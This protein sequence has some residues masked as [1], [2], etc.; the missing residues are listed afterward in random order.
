MSAPAVRFTRKPCSPR[1]AAYVSAKQC[2]AVARRFGGIGNDVA[3]RVLPGS[4]VL[5]NTASSDGG[6]AGGTVAC[7]NAAQADRQPWLARWTAAGPQLPL[8]C[9][10]GDVGAS[11]PIDAV[12]TPQGSVVALFNDALTTGDFAGAEV[13]GTGARDSSA[14][15]VLDSTLQTI[16]R[17][18]RISGEPAQSVAVRPDGCFMVTQRGGTP[19]AR[20]ISTR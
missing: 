20:V 9:L 17:R 5:G 13:V 15:L 16:T 8:R 3:T 6:A 1:R 12:S 11:D 14:V 4:I 2:L 19:G 18:L 10:S 7:P